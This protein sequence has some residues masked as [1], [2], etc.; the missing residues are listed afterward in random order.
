MG[1]NMGIPSQCG[2][3]NSSNSRCVLNFNHGGAHAF[4]EDTWAFKRIAELEAEVR[5][6]QTMEGVT[7]GSKYHP[8]TTK[9]LPK[10]HPQTMGGRKGAC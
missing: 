6:Q 3:V 2:E 7:M 1:K 10:G 8:A 5:H 9:P 4:L